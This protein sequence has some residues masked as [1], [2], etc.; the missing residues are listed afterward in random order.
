MGVDRAFPR[1][2]FR[3]MVHMTSPDDGT[4]RMFVVLQRGRILVFPNSPSVGSAITFLDI[5]DRVSDE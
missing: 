1:L 4:N 3:L 5:R 2:A